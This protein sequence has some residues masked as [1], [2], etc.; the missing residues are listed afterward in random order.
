MLTRSVSETIGQSQGGSHGGNV[1]AWAARTGT[2]PDTWLDLST[3]INPIPYPLPSFA[4][5]DWRRLPEMESMAE[6][7]SAAA[8]AYRA[9]GPDWVAA[10]P[11]TQALIQRLPEILTHAPEEG[12]RILSPT[13]NEH[14]HV[15]RANGVRVEEVPGP[16]LPAPDASLLLVNPNNPDGTAFSPDALLDWLNRAPEHAWLI[17]DEAFAD[18]SPALS[19]VPHLT[20]ARRVVVLRSFGKF[21]GLAGVRLGF[22]AAPPSI[23]ARVR[24][25]LGPWAVAGPAI[26][27]GVQ[28]LL[29]I[30][31][32]AGARRRLS[33]DRKRLEILLAAAGVEPVGGTDLFAFAKTSHAPSLFGHL[34]AQRI[35][36]RRFAAMPENLR[37]GFPGDEGAWRRL[38]GA[39]RSWDRTP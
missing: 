26:R 15:W 21:F 18:V 16:A 20:E 5:D 29:D 23:A 33:A 1:R 39:L 2:E 6:L 28:G 25:T 19:I 27:L 31:W 32:Q 14:A 30:S 4:A 34:I 11:G 36:V 12:I 7:L 37:L 10:V 22:A 13:Y 8:R 9:P 17:V 35:L 3:G 24:E 38:G